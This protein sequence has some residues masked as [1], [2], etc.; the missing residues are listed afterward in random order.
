MA[1]NEKVLQEELA[2][3]QSDDFEKTKKSVETMRKKLLIKEIT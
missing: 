2:I 1:L 3:L